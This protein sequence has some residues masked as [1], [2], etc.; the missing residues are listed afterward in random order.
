MAGRKYYMDDIKRCLV[1]AYTENDKFILEMIT[2]VPKYRGGYHRNTFKKEFDT[3]GNAN[4]YFKKVRDNNQLK[5]VTF[6]G[7]ANGHIEY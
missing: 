7:M 4:N 2:L 3:P 1:K 6:P 5:E